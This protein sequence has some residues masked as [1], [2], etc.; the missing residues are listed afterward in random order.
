MAS[1]LP[2]PKALLADIACC[3]GFYTRLPIPDPGERDFAAAQWAAPIAGVV[4]GLMV[5]TTLG[6]SHALGVAAPLAAALA[7]AAGAL[8]TGALHE[9]GLADVADGFGGGQTRERKLEIMK[10][11]RVGSYGVIALV[12][13]LLMRW[14]ALAMLAASGT[15]TMIAVLVG[16]HAA[17]RA[18]IPAF[19]ARVQPARPDG[20]SAGVGRVDSQAA[21]YAAII[22]FLLLLPV[23]LGFALVAALLVVALSLWLERL[24]MR[25]IGGQTGDVLGTLQQCC[26]IAVLAAATTMLI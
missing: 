10:D 23:G 9:D 25:Q 26:E 18:A 6:L 2:D 24:A 7:L 19:M 15:F 11:S 21:L 22:G 4:V 8:L 3:V 1:S 20:L 12:L 5:G 14:S 13:S 17:S 16:A